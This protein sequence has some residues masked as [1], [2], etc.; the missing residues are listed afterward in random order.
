[1]R[2]EWNIFVE[3]FYRITNMSL[4]WQNRR[5]QQLIKTKGNIIAVPSLAIAWDFTDWTAKITSI[6][7]YDIASISIDTDFEHCVLCLTK[8]TCVYFCHI[9]LIQHS[10]KHFT[11][12][13]IT[14]SRMNSLTLN[15]GQCIL[16]SFSYNIK[17]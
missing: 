17:L 9:F 1:M 11:N 6:P 2:F 8:C 14:N 16:F 7:V 5:Q 12:L 15:G 13:I 4:I 3:F 10:A